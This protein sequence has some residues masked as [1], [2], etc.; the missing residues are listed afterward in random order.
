MRFVTALSASVL[1]TTRRMT[2]QVGCPSVS[3]QGPSETAAAEL[4]VGLLSSMAVSRPLALAAPAAL[5]AEVF[6]AI[7][8]VTGDAIGEI[9]LLDRTALVIVRVFVAA[10]V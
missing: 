10:P 8:A 5:P 1:M 6:G 7:E 9:L 4:F 2:S 3:G